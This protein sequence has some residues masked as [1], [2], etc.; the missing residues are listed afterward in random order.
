MRKYIKWAVVLSTM[1]FA[2]Y[3]N[4]VNAFAENSD[5][6]KYERDYL[7]RV[8]DSEN[9]LEGTTANCICSDSKGFLWFGGYTGLY[10]YDGV[11]FKKY[12]MDDRALPVN[13]IVQDE[14]E[15]LWIGTNGEGVYRFDGEDFSE[16][17]LNDV[18]RGA[19]VINKMYLDSDGIIWIGT[20][21]GLFSIDISDTKK[22]A[23]E[24]SR[25]DN[26]IIRD[27]G[28]TSS[29]EKIII[30]KTGEVSLLKGNN[31]R[32]LELDLSDKEGIPR[33]CTTGKDGV[34]YI[35]TTGDEIV[36]VSNKG[37]ILCR[38]K[39]NGLSSFN[40]IYEL[41]RN[42]FWVCSDTGIGILKGNTISKMEF[43]LNDSVEGGCRDYQG[44]YWF[45][46]SR[47][48][49]LQIYENHFSNLG[50]YWQLNQTVNAI[51]NYEGKT[52]VGCDDGLYCFKGKKRI[53]D[54]LTKSCE[55]KRIRQIYL[56]REDNLWISTYQD[57]LKVLYADGRI[58]NYT[59]ADS[60]LETNQIRCVWQRENK[61]TLIGTEEGLY[62]CSVDGKIQK[63]TKDSILNTKRILDVTEDEEGDIYVAT[64]G[65]GIYK[66]KNM[67]V[68]SIYSKQNGLLSNVT[69]K[70]V[71]SNRMDGEWVVT[72]EGICFIDRKGKIK[73]VTGI[74][75]A[76]S[77]DILLD[78]DRAVILAG[79]GFFEAKEK[80]LLAKNVSYTH[81][82]KQDGLP[83]DFT[84]NAGNTIKDGTLY[85]CGTTGATSIK[86]N[87]QQPGRMIRLYVN[88]ITEDEKEIGTEKETEKDQKG[89]L[90]SERGAFEDEVV[91]G[92]IISPS[93][94]RINIDVR[95]INFVH[96]N[97][98]VG[99]FLEGM[100]KQET[101]TDD[102]GYDISYT[103]L[104]GGSYIYHYKVYDEESKKCISE[105]SVSLTKK[106]KFYEE[107]RV[108]VLIIFLSIGMLIL[109]FILLI[110][111]RE[112]GVK[113]KYYLEFLQE[114]EDEIS[115]LA[116]RDLVT[117]VY[118]RNYFE[119]EK[120]N[121]D[122]KKMSALL[123]VS[124]NH[125]EYFKG[126]YGIFFM[127][128]ILRKGVKILQDCS[129][130][131]IK[132]CRVS[133]NI[134]YFW[135]MEPVHLETY[136]YDIKEKFKELGEQEN[137][138]Y[139][140]SVGAIYNNTVGKENIDELID[141]CGKMR[142]LDEKHAEAQFVESKMKLL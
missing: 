50:S 92:N 76:N 39:G 112:K 2:V 27:I 114:K 89:S 52:Y 74:P 96:Q 68:Q 36:K 20:K 22:T 123:S 135:F 115:E 31:Y 117:G 88:S 78:N 63:L 106:Y 41:E 82:D 136:I 57:G 46:S 111:L 102:L 28:E 23:V 132:I 124:V 64:D 32:R 61:E 80:E 125:A 44:N 12:L 66:I 122:L 126:K 5:A 129:T 35:G 37:K 9:G 21:A 30:Q 116:Y 127:E 7:S 81:F 130:E 141:R 18:V 55:K 13:D 79:N 87:E 121:I 119:H 48:G 4:N 11:E 93:A 118:N 72:G 94:H 47:Q 26:T 59:M 49:I 43:A 67:S 113:R 91:S 56:D 58:R 105:L 70:I 133:E 98:Y 8:F 107:P 51:Q 73:Q 69:M 1:F 33:C 60:G 53:Q 101:L 40:A 34:F 71:P 137:I 65:Y 131:K 19:S 100:D 99:Y 6:E 14:E 108:K 84:A 140:F 128:N 16:Y 90:L 29:G 54:K 134:F 139:S 103:N 24:Y 86:L 109:L 10:R 62:S 120:E 17:K 104:D 42:D 85:M 38:I 110:G 142:L 97:V 75:I 25:F 138:P 83:V 77:L 45:V 95:M 15:N 3:F